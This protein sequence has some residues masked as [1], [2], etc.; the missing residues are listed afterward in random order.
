MHAVSQYVRIVP[1]FKD[2]SHF[3][4]YNSPHIL[5]PASDTLLPRHPN[6]LVFLLPTSSKVVSLLSSD[7]SIRFIEIY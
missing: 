5:P 3:L 7:V 2:S 1:A 4:T 6:Q